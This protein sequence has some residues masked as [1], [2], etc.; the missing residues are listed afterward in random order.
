MIS[1]KDMYVKFLKDPNSI[2]PVLDVFLQFLPEDSKL[3]Q[4]AIWN[5]LDDNLIKGDASKMNGDVMMAL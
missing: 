5:A 2:D 3:D 1:H 4:D